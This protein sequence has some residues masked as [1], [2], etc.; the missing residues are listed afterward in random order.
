ML[1]LPL[2]RTTMIMDQYGYTGSGCL[3][4]ALHQAVSAGCIRRGDKVMLIASGAGFF[5]GANIFRY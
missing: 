4:M 3:P 1:G 5:V 2:E